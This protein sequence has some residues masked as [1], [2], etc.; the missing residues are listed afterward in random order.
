M[1]HPGS[2]QLAVHAQVEKLAAFR[3]SGE[4]GQHALKRPVLFAM[5]TTRCG[6]PSSHLPSLSYFKPP[7]DS[8]RTLAFQSLLGVRIC[9]V[10]GAGDRCDRAGCVA[11]SYYVS[12]SG[13]LK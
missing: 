1:E 11:S 6:Q 9:V 5:L 8:L 12:T 3:L 4:D 2:C 10:Y 13:R 7:E